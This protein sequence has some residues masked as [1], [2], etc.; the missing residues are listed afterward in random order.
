MMK[1]RHFT[2]WWKDGLKTSG[3]VW[4]SLFLLIL[5]AGLRA[6][7]FDT[8]RSY[9]QGQ[10]GGSYNVAT[11]NSYWTS[12]NTNA[13]RTYLWSDLPL[14]SVSANIS[15]TYGRLYTMAQAWAA[16]ASS[17]SG[18]ASLASAITNSLDWMAA[19]I[20]TPS[21][22][23][24]DNWWDWEIGSP[25][26]F[27]NVVTLMYP[28]LTGTQI[29][30]YNNAVDHF[31]PPTKSW[32][33]GANLT[34][35]CKVVLIR[36][37]LGRNSDKLT[38]AQ[39]NLSPV[40]PYVTSGDGF[41]T[42][43]SFVQHTVI[44][45]TGTYGNVLLGDLAQLVNLLNGSAWQIT[46]PNL[47][48]IYA[49]VSNSFQPLIYHGAMMDMVRGRAISRSS[50]TELSDGAGTIA[51]VRSIAQFAP[52][53]T[54]MAFT[55]W[56]NAPSL[57]SGQ[58]HFAG[59]DRVV[60][61]RAGFG[62][63]LSLSSTRIANYECI[64]GENLH[65]WFTG[66]GM[67]YLYLGNTETQFAG[68]FWPTVDPYHLPG[69]TVETNTR[70]NAAG[71]ATKTTQNWAGGAQVANT[72]GVAGMSLAAY[73]T[74]LTAKKSWFMFD[75]EIVCLGAGIT[76][77]GGSGID[78]TVENRR[79][80]A[81]PTNNFTV[82]GV[83]YPPMAGWS[84]SPANVSWC[85][86]DGVG[87]YYFPG[88]ATNLQVTLSTN[89][90]AWSQIN[91]GTATNLLTDNYLK[92]W[93]SHGLRPTNAAYAYVLRPNA[94][95]NDMNAYAASPDI[96][97]LT[98]TATVQAVSKPALGV[99]AAN[100][101]VD[102]TNSADLITVNKKASVITRENLSSLSIGI[103]DPA[104]TNTGS[105]SV[106]LNRAAINAMSVD[107]GV[108][109][110]Q[111]SPKII[112]SVNVKGAHGKSF[113]AVFNYAAPD[114]VWDANISVAAAQD[115]SGFWPGGGNNWWSASGD[116]A[117]DDTA[118]YG[119]VFGAGGTAGTVTM[120]SAHTVSQLTFNPVATGAYKLS[121]AGPLSISNGIIANASAT[122]AAGLNLLA[123]QN[124]LVASNQI[125]NINGSVAAL[126]PVTISLLGAGA[127]SLNGT[128][129]MATNLVTL[130]FTDA[131]NQTV[132]NLAN[133]P[134]AVSGLSLNDGVTGIIQ[135]NG[136]LVMN[137]G[138]WYFGSANLV[139]DT[140]DL[141]GLNNFTFNVPDSTFSVGPNQFPV[142]GT[143]SATMNWGATNTL[144]AANFYVAGFYGLG[145]PGFQGVLNLGQVNNVNANTIVIGSTK[146]SS[147]VAFRI[148]LTNPSVQIRAADGIGPAAMT[149]GMQNNYAAQTTTATFDVS[150]GSLDALVGTLL[151]GNAVDRDGTLT[152]NVLMGAGNLVVSNLTIGQ[153]QGS[154]VGTYTRTSTGTFQLTG[155]NLNADTIILGNNLAG[156][157]TG[158][159]TA[160]G[161][162]ILSSGTLRAGILQSGAS[163]GGGRTG[164]LVWSD[165]TLGN[166][167]GSNLNI[168]GLDLN[169]TNAGNIS[170]THA[171]EVTAAQTATVQGN[172]IGMGALSKTGAGALQLSGTN[173][174]VGPTQ[175]SAGVL[176]VNGSLA[177]ASTVTVTADAR[178]CGSGTVN[179]SVTVNGMISPGNDGVGMLTTGAENWNADGRYQL[180]IATNG[181][182]SNGLAINGPLTVTATTN[183][184]FVIQL[185]SSNH[186]AEFTAGSNHSW[187]LALV[188]GGFTNFNPAAF[189]V[190][191]SGFTPIT[192][193]VFQVATNGSALTLNYTAY[194]PPVIT[195][196]GL[197]APGVFTMNLSGPSGQSYRILGSTNVA[198]ALAEWQ[199]LTNGIF[200]SAD[201][202]SFAEVM[203]TNQ[204]KFY[205]GVSP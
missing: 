152:A 193:G 91:T 64:N 71:E 168:N 142:A 130:N 66:D 160:N 32:M 131:Q 52:S 55:N 59:M 127:V 92:L 10:L 78:T 61:L 67:T 122:I 30:N 102:G 161:N 69:T 186:P 205:R 62:F 93:F 147:H 16:P 73:G 150:A 109:V 116:M 57:P 58:F 63:G 76:C 138:N 39:T 60:A 154:T 190:D 42:D 96:V 4:W 140:L 88:G 36:A 74:T 153:A 165:G 34:D 128:N 19:H 26:T 13:S 11:A 24:Y 18:N 21:A 113:Q 159:A 144:T 37:I 77:G 85:A 40:F 195:C 12:L 119:A 136:T 20:Y 41:Y 171:F 176:A 185:V 38:Y 114:L 169:L 29:T 1:H 158:T 101:W 166:L 126:V 107:A 95:A 170:G 94:T 181:D 27:N 143:G 146:Q 5:P 23:E 156:N 89:T 50:E 110:V 25:Q 49:W 75:N 53:V 189:A 118:A 17:L 172:L 105:I 2:S 6:D 148:G 137:Y 180:Y 164:T 132:L 54:A 155:G 197:G 125:L 82:N 204:Q 7:Q 200:D 15:S 79:L 194:V 151:I 162:F 35:K 175:V 123:N 141:S 149:V 97:V 196:F 134:Q 31:S 191:A 70:V 145:Q 46:D 22:S 106:T 51:S 48:N 3:L 157:G 198:L 163:T 104:Q 47:N 121:G 45:Y 167:A 173:I 111:L 192:T 8:L 83:A 33:T 201:A 87:G 187:T 112:L 183:A 188:S 80:G 44:A 90:G 68:D 117:W 108:T 174:Y 65:G 199:V 203:A 103:A 139:S 120:L 43:G 135:G 115:G 100:F 86:L 178:L 81:A 202:A 84:L 129:Q 56:A 99:V 184:P 14:G 177:A 98:N 179:G 133:G 72:Y 9:W 182:A 124:W 28:A